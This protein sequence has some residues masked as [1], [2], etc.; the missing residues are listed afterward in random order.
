[1][2]Q[3]VAHVEA[4][5]DAPLAKKGKALDLLGGGLDRNNENIIVDFW[6]KTSCPTLLALCVFICLFQNYF[7]QTIFAH[8]KYTAR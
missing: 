6:R 7:T 5:L 8:S 2:T 3:G 1:M 4:L